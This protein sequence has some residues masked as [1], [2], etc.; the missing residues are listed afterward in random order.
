MFV[1]AYTA[2]GLNLTRAEAAASHVPTEFYRLDAWTA[3]VH[4]LGL[5]NVIQ[6]TII[7]AHVG[8]E[9]PNPAIFAFAMAT[10]GVTSSSDVWMI[11]DHPIVDVKG[12]ENVGI[13][14]LLT[15]AAYPDS[16]GMSVLDAA[17]RIAQARQWE[18]R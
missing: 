17:R 12:A 2:N 8:A 11:G 1:A 5:A 13:S 14:A 6:L 4:S 15:G 16:V 10:V 7:S 9:K 18:D 3:L